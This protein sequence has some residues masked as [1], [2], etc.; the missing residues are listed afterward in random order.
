MVSKG[1]AAAVVLAAALAA[2]AVAAPP[3]APPAAPARPA[4]RTP[5]NGVQRVADTDKVCMVNDRYMGTAQI[6]VDVGGKRYYG[7]CA[8]CKERLAKDRQARMAVDPVS[9]KEVDK[10]TAVIGQ[11]PDGS[12]LYFENDANRKK[13][14]AR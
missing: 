12:V 5:A 11:R 6:P 1:S 2:S 4:A 7:C 13:Y 14:R 3:A 9:G 10:A 8:M